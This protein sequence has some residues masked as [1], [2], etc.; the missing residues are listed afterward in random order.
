MR[1]RFSW[2]DSRLLGLL[3]AL[4]F[5][6]TLSGCKGIPQ[7]RSAI[8]DVT[9]RGND[10]IDADDVIDKLATQKSSKFLFFFR[11]LVF[12][13]E[14]FDRFILQR[15]LARVERFYRGRGYYDAHARAGRVL[16]TDSDHDHVRIEIVVEEGAPVVVNEVKV[17][18]IEGLPAV[19][20]DAA[21]GGAAGLKKG[22]PFDEEAFDGATLAIRRALTDR[23]YAYAK[24][25]KAAAVDLVAHTADVVFTVTPDQKSKF[26]PVTIEG[27]G[28]LPEAPIRRAIDIKEGDDYSTAALDDAAQAVL[29]L[30]VVSSLE[31]KP[32]LPDVPPANH[33]VALHVKIEPA[34]LHT[35][36]LGGG[37]Q[38]DAARTDLHLLAGWESHNFFGGLRTFRVEFRPGVVLYPMRVDNLVPP[39]AILPEERLRLELRQPGFLEAR[40]TLFVRP[41]FNIRAFLPP[42]LPKSESVIGFREIKNAIGVD[43]TIWKLYGSLAYNFVVENPFAYIGPPDKY[44]RTLV[45][46][47]PQLL[48]TLDFRDDKVHPHKGIFLG[49]DLQVAGIGGNVSD[50]KIQPEI[51]GYVPIVKRV[52][53]AMRGTVGFLFPQNY[54]DVVQKRLNLPITDANR[55]ERTREFEIMYFR[56]LFSGGPSSNRGYALRGIA[57]HAVVPFLNPTSVSQLGCNDPSASTSPGQESVKGCAVPVGGLSLWEASAEV[58][59]TVSGPLEAATFCDSSDVSP[60]QLSIRPDHPHVSC[61]L[62]ARNDTPVGPIRLDIG[63]RLPGLQVPKPTLSGTNAPFSTSATQ[64]LPG[65]PLY[66]ELIEASPTT[67]L[68]LPIAVSFGIG[69]AF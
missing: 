2:L 52:T 44:L 53:F 39:T 33:I 40:T 34:R 59:V 18:G 38:F 13:Y 22:E 11:G 16:E 64:V 51:R 56:G 49:N 14:L 45:I 21:R 65:T 27:L 26:G 8:D 15:D 20:F 25:K 47:S 62:G 60:R 55:A 6:I 68:G 12:E 61:G 46:S 29:D 5:L 23:G 36:R 17:E 3:A 30:G 63:Y 35:I 10:K 66:D 43:R 42:K 24:V 57:P 19:D 69:E 67:I 4:V 58:R 32:D 54:G 41:E 37:F 1:S 48:T 31:I 28:P 9:V 50:L 7:G